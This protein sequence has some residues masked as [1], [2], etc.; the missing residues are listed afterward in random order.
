MDFISAQMSAHGDI[1]ERYAELGRL[2]ERKLW[3]QLTVDRSSIRSRRP[4]PRP[5]PRRR[6]RAGGCGVGEGMGAGFQ[7][8]ITKEWM[9]CRAAAAVDPEAAAAGESQSMVIY[10]GCEDADP[11]LTVVPLNIAE[12]ASGTRCCA[13]VTNS[14]RA[15]SLGLSAKWVAPC[16]NLNKDEGTLL[17]GRRRRR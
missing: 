5:S 15:E 16:G 8:P 17:C 10:Q 11:K 12:F 9:T 1:A 7:V 6:L 2:F 13:A 3:H 4:P 14:T